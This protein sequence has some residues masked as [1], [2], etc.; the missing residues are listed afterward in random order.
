MMST[1]YTDE[2]GY[3]IILP[4]G[5]VAAGEVEV[6]YTAEEFFTF[7]VP[8][9][10]ITAYSELGPKDVLIPPT[11]GGVPVLVLGETSF[12]PDWNGMEIDSV[13]IPEGVTTV[14]DSAFYYNNL[15]EVVL[16]STISIIELWAFE[17]NQ[18]TIVPDVSGTALTALGGFD[19]NPIASLT[20]P[21]NITSISD[22]GFA[23]TDLTE[24]IK[25]LIMWCLG[26]MPDFVIAL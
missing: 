25:Y 6:A 17:S 15:T 22:Y 10:T 1:L 3:L 4:G 26:E 12:S 18:I 13:V 9:Q 2:N 14:G 8:T 21:L 16:P 19:S 7:D 5:G 11:I 20:I 24:L 23:W